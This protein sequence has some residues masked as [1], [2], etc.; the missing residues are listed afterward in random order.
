MLAI[1]QRLSSLGKDMSL[2]SKSRA[3]KV[4]LIQP[5][6][7]TDQIRQCAQ[8]DQAYI[9]ASLKGAGKSL[10]HLANIIPKS[11]VVRPAPS[12]VHADAPEQRGDASQSH[13]LVPQQSEV[14]PQPHIDAPQAA[15]LQAG[16]SAQPRYQPQVPAARPVNMAAQTADTGSGHMYQPIR[17]EATQ[18]AVRRR[19][20]PPLPTP[21]VA[22]MQ[23]ELAKPT[24]CYKCGQLRA[25]LKERLGYQQTLHDNDPKP[26]LIALIGSEHARAGVFA[27]TC[28]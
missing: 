12:Q 17:A 28:F 8:A 3:G 2:L 9:N 5:T 4:K 20:P 14:A 18:A 25:Y 19:Q 26:Y 13:S 23:R 21:E 15:D 24:G 6:S 1:G 27:T 11:Y 10:S 7:L 16:Q 22:D